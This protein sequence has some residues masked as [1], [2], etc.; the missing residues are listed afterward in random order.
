MQRIIYWSG[1]IKKN[2]EVITDA[3][4]GVGLE[5]SKEKEK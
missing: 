5:A 4:K 1:A 2:S 3:S